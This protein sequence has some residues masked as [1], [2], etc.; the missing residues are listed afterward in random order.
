MNPVGRGRHVEQYDVV[1]FAGSK[2]TNT[3]PRA[4]HVI[5]A[6]HRN[7]ASSRDSS[8]RLRLLIGG[9]GT[10]AWI[11]RPRTDYKEPTASATTEDTIIERVEHGQPIGID[12]DQLIMAVTID[13]EYLNAACVCGA[14]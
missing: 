3:T 8:S 5:R 4:P 6:A 2:P 11:N 9:A 14:Q 7:R 1:E 10:E 12:T 13:H